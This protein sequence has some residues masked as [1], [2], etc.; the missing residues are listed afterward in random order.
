MVMNAYDEYAE[1][2]FRARLANNTHD[3]SWVN[4]GFDVGFTATYC[5][6]GAG[7]YYLYRHN[8]TDCDRIVIPVE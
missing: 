5:G 2:R 7:T 4:N 1:A 6:C 8:G 3:V